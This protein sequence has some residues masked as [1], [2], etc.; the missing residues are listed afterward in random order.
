MKIPVDR[1]GLLKWGAT[2]AISSILPRV[3]LAADTRMRSR[4]PEKADLI[5]L[6]DRPP[7]LETPLHYFRQDL[8]PNEA[9]FVRWHLAGVPTR[10]D[11]GSFRLRVDGAVS[12]PLSLSIDNLKNDFEAVELV[13]LNQCSGNSRSF[14]EPRVAGSQW[15]HGAMGN[16]RWTGV[17][18][19]D[20]LDRA[21]LN[22]GAAG[23]GL[24]GLD[25]SPMPTLPDMRKSIEVDHALD[26]NVMVAYLMNGEPLPLLNGFPCRLVVPGWYATYWIKSLDHIEALSSPLHNIWMDTAYRVPNNP[27]AVESEKDLAKDTVP[28]NRFSIHS[29]FVR[30]EPDEVL[31]AGQPYQLEGLA[32]DSGYGITGVDVSVDGGASWLA[33]KLDPSLGNFSWRRWR[34]DWTPSARGP[35]SLKVKETNTA[36]EQQLQEQWNHGG[37]ARRVI[38]E[39]RGMVV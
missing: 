34:L 37:Y 4:F 21:G 25:K 30:P 7:Q 16:A 29:I 3:P 36:G 23:I 26:G 32:M 5:L 1:R 22:S 9:Y 19:K 15:K 6:T 27:T 35:F 10:V 39:T 20:I 12:T 31:T 28:I 2:A 38:E 18:L 33:A 24:S 17:R 11:L 8:T 14:F 13:A